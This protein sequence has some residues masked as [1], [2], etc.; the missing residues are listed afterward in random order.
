MVR[1]TWDQTWL[2][3]LLWVANFF[4]RF[5]V[6]L[7]IYMRV[8]KNSKMKQDAQH[9]IYLIVTVRLWVIGISWVSRSRTSILD[10]GGTGTTNRSFCWNNSP[11]NRPLVVTISLTISCFSDTH[12]HTFERSANKYYIGSSIWGPSSN[13]IF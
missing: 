2:L 5:N 6:K 13:V 11:L 12:K 3:L 7:S 9:Q 10:I 1:G 4:R 8:I